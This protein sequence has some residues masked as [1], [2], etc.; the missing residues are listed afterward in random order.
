MRGFDSSNLLFSFCDLLGQK[1][2][3]LSLLLLLGMETALLES[4]QMTTALEALWCNQSL[5]FGTRDELARGM[6][7]CKI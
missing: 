3:V 1:G 5:D 2:I 7:G 6:V 4:T